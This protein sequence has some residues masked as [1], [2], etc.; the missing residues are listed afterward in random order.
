MFPQRSSREWQRSLT[1]ARS[2][3]LGVNPN[4]QRHRGR[5]ARNF[6]IARNIRYAELKRLQTFPILNKGRQKGGLIVEEANRRI[7]L[8]DQLAGRTIGYFNRESGVGVGLEGAFNHVL[9][10]HSGKRFE[11]LVATNVWRPIFGNQ[12]EPENGRDIV[13]TIDMRIQDVAHT[14]LERTLRNS[15]A[16]HGTAILMEVSTGKIR[17][18]VNLKRNDRTGNYYEVENFAVNESVEPGSTFKLASLNAILE[19]GRVDTGTLVPRGRM[20]VGDRVLRDVRDTTGKI[21]LKHAFE[22]SSNVG[23]AYAARQTFS[24][25]NERKFREYFHRMRLHRP[26]GLEIRGERNPVILSFDEQ[27]KNDTWWNGSLE[28]TSMGYEVQMTPLQQLTFYNAVANNGRMMKPMFVEEIRSGGQIVRRFEPTVLERSIASERTLR[29]VRACLEGVVQYGTARSLAR[30]HVSI[31]GKT[32]TAQINYSERGVE[33]TRHRASFIG[34]FPADNPQFSCLVVVSNPSGIRIHG[35]EIAAPVFQAIAER[36]Y[37]THVNLGR[38]LPDLENFQPLQLA[39]NI[40]R[41]HEIKN[42]AQS[43]RTL[44]NVR[45]MTARDAVYL[46]EGLGYKVMLNGRGVVREQSISAGTAIVSGQQITLR[47][48]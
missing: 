8:H 27:R 13:T 24:G 2:R 4:T 6:L 42:T 12:Q 17:A 26:L 45:G 47:L 46:L 23:L 32:G 43:S 19:E 16:T 48:S 10:G 38:E 30:S 20:Q 1:E 14:A 36:V 34:Y 7:R 35:G 15:N 41:L 37:A 31:A 44:P 33:R 5:G 39:S 11:Q 9:E 21:T 29:K 18:I 25:R 28:W 22:L 40:E 3:D